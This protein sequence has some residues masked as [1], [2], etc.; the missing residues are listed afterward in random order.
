MVPSSV[1]PPSKSNATRLVRQFAP[2]LVVT[3]WQ[4]ATGG[5]LLVTA[6]QTL[7]AVPVKSRQAVP[8]ARMTSVPA[9]RPV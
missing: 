4:T 2:A 7:V 8:V 1:E 9:T 5:M 6:I 3:L